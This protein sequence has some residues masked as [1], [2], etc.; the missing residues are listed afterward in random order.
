MNESMISIKGGESTRLFK[1]IPSQRVRTRMLVSQCSMFTVGGE[2]REE[3]YLYS[4]AEGHCITG[5]SS[6]S[7]LQ[8]HLNH[9]V[10]YPFFSYKSESYNS[11]RFMHLSPATVDH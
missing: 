9:K 10:H 2:E 7:F 6:S 11:V 3:D 5:P 4:D 1:V 8:Q